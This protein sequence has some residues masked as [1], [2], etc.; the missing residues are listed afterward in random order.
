[1]SEITFETFR[2]A[3]QEATTNLDNPEGEKEKKDR[4]AVLRE[5]ISEELAK[6]KK[7]IDGD[8]VEGLAEAVASKLEKMIWPEKDLEIMRE[9]AREEVRK[10]AQDG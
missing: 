10:V 5:M 8:E 2:K 7:D 3:A 6:M 1:M 9:R 4:G